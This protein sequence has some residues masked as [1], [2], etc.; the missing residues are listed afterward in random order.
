[1][2]RLFGA[3]ETWLAGRYRL[4]GEL[5][6]GGLGIV[7]AAHDTELDRKVA[8]KLIRA[9]AV[10]HVGADTMRRRLRREARAMAKLRDP[11]VVTVFDVGQDG[12][13]LFIAMELVPGV[14]LRE[15]CDAQPRAWSEIRDVLIGAGQGLAVAHAHGLV[16]RDFK[17]SNVLVDESGHPR[18]LD[19]GLACA[20]GA[21]PLASD[22]RPPESLDDLTR[23][24]TLLGTPRYMSP[25]QFEGGPVDHRSDQWAFCTTAYELLLGVAPFAGETVG[26][27]KQAVVGEA[28]LQR[29]SAPTSVPPWLIAPIVRGLAR[30]PEQRNP[31]MRELLVAMRSGPE[32]TRWSAAKIVGLVAIVVIVAVAVAVVWGSMRPRAPSTQ[33]PRGH[34]RAEEA[35]PVS[36]VQVSEL[37][38]Q[39][40]TPHQ[41]RWAWDADGDP[42]GLLHYELILGPSAAA[43]RARG[44]QTRRVGPEHNAE[45]SR[46]LLPKTTSVDRV[47]GTTTEYHQPRT[48]V[49]AQL[50]A[51]DTSGNT[52]ASNVAGI[53]TQE[54]PTHELVVLDESG[55]AGV[56]IPPGFE[57]ADDFP[58]RGTAHYRYDVDCEARAECWIVMRRAGL[59]VAIPSDTLSEGNYNTTAYLQLAVAVVG[60]TPPW[61]SEIWIWYTDAAHSTSDAD[62]SRIAL[63][64]GFTAHADG[65]YH[66]LEVPL[67][68]FTRWKGQSVPY[69]EVV[70]FGLDMIGVS[71][72]W[73]DGARIYVDD[74]RVR[75]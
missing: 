50:V 34:G 54:L 17:P 12:E 15:W 69:D 1:M 26:A 14:T 29:P 39:W 67:R 72:S 73:T 48:Q 4:E 23:T 20:T 37:R 51:T 75:W 64:A 32:S 46:F 45:L 21:M 66:V 56:S 71:G 44:P 62:L 22:T 57:L 6:R 49:F 63:F 40:A 61:W 68:A 19:F 33:V 16:H 60:A 55:V 28:E 52:S 47:Q 9:E 7:Y 42:D 41:I 10:A 65:D 18:V 3:S 38:A 35:S 30:A 8:V 25:E 53:W 31:A 11:H 2:A 36:A 70:R 43:V 27:L 74:V 5:G 24:G 13:S 58:S 59:G